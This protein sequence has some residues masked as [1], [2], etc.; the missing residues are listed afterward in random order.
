M[1]MPIL[2]ARVSARV[3]VYVYVHGGKAKQKHP[4]SPLPLHTDRRG[5]DIQL[6]RGVKVDFPLAAPITVGAS[7]NLVNKVKAEPAG[8]PAAGG[9]ATQAEKRDGW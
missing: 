6:I 8:R 3:C 2:V 1:L 4:R 7:V 9:K 5:Q